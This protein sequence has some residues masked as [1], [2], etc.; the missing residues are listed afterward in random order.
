LRTYWEIDDLDDVDIVKWRQ[1]R[2]NAKA[3]V[4]ETVGNRLKE[5]FTNMYGTEEWADVAVS[6]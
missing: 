6:L 5:L 4:G 2:L 1:T 3:L